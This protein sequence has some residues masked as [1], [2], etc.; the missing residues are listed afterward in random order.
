[1]TGERKAFG[2]NLLKKKEMFERAIIRII[3]ISEVDWKA[4]V[5]RNIRPNVSV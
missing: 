3:I 1:M 4:F 2:K 5:P